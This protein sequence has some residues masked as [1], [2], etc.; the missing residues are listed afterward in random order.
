LGLPAQLALLADW[1]VPF[2]VTAKGW[3]S[4]GATAGAP[5]R[6]D[7]KVVPGAARAGLAGWLGEALKVRVAVPAEKGK[8]NAAVEALLCAAL[9]LPRGG[10]RI[11][12][13]RHSTRKVVEIR[14]LSRSEILERLAAGSA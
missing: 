3:R 12:S 13:G 6:L 8:A 1:R 9:H 10:A 14:G 5:E 11:V 2:T 7:V 4:L